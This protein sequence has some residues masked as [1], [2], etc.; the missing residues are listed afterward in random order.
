MLLNKPI[1][2]EKLTK[3]QQKLITKWRWHRLVST[4]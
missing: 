4:G 3:D 2:S 1:F